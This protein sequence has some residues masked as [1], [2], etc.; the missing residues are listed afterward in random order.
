MGSLCQCKFSVLKTQSL[1]SRPEIADNWHHT[2]NLLVSSFAF[3]PAEAIRISIQDKSHQEYLWFQYFFISMDWLDSLLAQSFS[4]WLLLNPIHLN[5]L[6]PILLNFP[7]PILL[8]LVLTQL[9]LNW[10]FP[11]LNR[12]KP[13]S[14]FSDHSS[15]ESLLTWSVLTRSLTLP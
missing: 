1:T 12:L 6:Y 9:F 11:C 14:F 7:Y 5:F 4:T 8:Y 13:A 2:G 15:L 3:T 10:T